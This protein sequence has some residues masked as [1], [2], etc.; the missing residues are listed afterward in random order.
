M[1]VQ[2]VLN[3]KMMLTALKQQPDTITQNSSYTHDDQS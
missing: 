3:V 2:V 1:S